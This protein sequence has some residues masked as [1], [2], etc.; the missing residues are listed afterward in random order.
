M[1]QSGQMIVLYHYPPNIDPENGYFGANPASFWHKFRVSNHGPMGCLLSHLSKK[2]GNKWKLTKSHPHHYKTKG[3]KTIIP[4]SSHHLRTYSHTLGWTA[5]V[6]SIILVL[7]FPGCFYARSFPGASKGLPELHPGPSQGLQA[8]RF[9]VCLFV[10]L[11]VCLSL[12]YVLPENVSPQPTSPFGWIF[13]LPR[14]C[15]QPLTNSSK[16]T[17]PLWFASINMNKVKTSSVEIPKDSMKVPN[18]GVKAFWAVKTPLNF[19]LRPMGK[20]ARIKIHERKCKM[21]TFCGVGLQVLNHK[22]K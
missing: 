16:S 14:H 2:I 19:P 17:R 6:S 10:C 3:N 8:L 5:C 21:L 20:K 13:F 15:M 4:L 12:L 7:F 22:K 1:H 11:F 9:E 18:L